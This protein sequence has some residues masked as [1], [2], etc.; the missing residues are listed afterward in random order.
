MHI[1]NKHTQ[2]IHINA[3][4]CLYKQTILEVHSQAKTTLSNAFLALEMG[5]LLIQT[6]RHSSHSKNTP[7]APKHTPHITRVYIN[8]T[9]L[10]AHYIQTFKHTRKQHARKPHNVTST[11]THTHT[12]K[13]PPSLPK[14]LPSPPPK[15]PPNPIPGPPK[16]SSSSPMKDASLPF[17]NGGLPPL[18]PPGLTLRGVKPLP[19]P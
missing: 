15:S 8:I 7:R 13:F 4:T 12:Q 6:L 3:H 9:S 1:H 11:H 14:S 19:A 18:P 16:S 10:N 17:M 5:V 2:E